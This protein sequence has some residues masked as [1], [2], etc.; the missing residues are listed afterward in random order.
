M[1]SSA[2]PEEIIRDLGAIG[3]LQPEDLPDLASQR[4]KVL[5]LMSD[6]RWHSTE[7]ILQAAGGSEGLRRLRELRK[8]PHVIIERFRQPIWRQWLYRLVVVASS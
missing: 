7:E 3:I 8:L 6:G 2:T 4:G 5:D 1:V